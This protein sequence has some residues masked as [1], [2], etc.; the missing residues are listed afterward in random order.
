LPKGTIAVYFLYRDASE[1]QCHV[2]DRRLGYRATSG[3]G[4]NS[5]LHL[6]NRIEMC[7]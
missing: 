3:T 7:N 5:G 6:G 1:A 2:R 4:G